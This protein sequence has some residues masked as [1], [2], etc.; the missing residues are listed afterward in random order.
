[1]SGRSFLAGMVTL[2]FTGAV[3]DGAAWGW[4]GEG[5]QVA[6]LVAEQ[7]LTDAAKAE[8]RSLLPSQQ[9]LNEISDRKVANWADEIREELPETGPWHYVD[10]PIEVGA[11]DPARDCECS[12]C[13]IERIRNL[14]RALAQKTEEN[15]MQ[16][17][18]ALKLLVHLMGDLHQPLHCAERKGADGKPDR[19]GNDY[20]VVYPGANPN[21]S[22]H[23]VWD[24]HL[25][26]RSIGG[27]DLAA[28][29]HALRGKI[30]PEMRSQWE[31]GTVQDWAQESHLAA[32]NAAYQG[33]PPTPGAHLLGEEYLN[34]AQKTVEEQ[35]QKAGVRL[36]KVLNEALKG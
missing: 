8:I 35:L 34:R 28:Y 13:I 31:E 6:A 2:G 9:D 19:G 26:K 15:L 16:R 3:L 33:L 36:A 22:L 10:I 25:V 21:P 12:N 23:A 1:M 4:G 20:E 17:R 27:K 14:Q 11:Y 29:A 30:T 7:Y 18:G 24:H 5:H 32:R